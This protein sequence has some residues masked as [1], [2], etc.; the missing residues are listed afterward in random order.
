[1]QKPKNQPAQQTATERST[2]RERERERE[3][4][5]RGGGVRVDPDPNSNSYSNL[6]EDRSCKQKESVEGKKNNGFN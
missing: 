1:M 3:G 4:E 6:K 5:K 2:Q